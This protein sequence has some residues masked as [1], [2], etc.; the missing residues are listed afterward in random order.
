MITQSPAK[1]GA[2]SAPK[3]PREVTAELKA[4]REK[5][6]ADLPKYQLGALWNVLDDALTPEPRTRSVP[7]LWKWSEVRPR[8]MRAGELVTAKEA[9]RRVLYFLNPGLP[10]EK[11]SAVG[12]LYAGIQLI[13][14]GE[15]AR[16][17]HHTPAATRFIIEGE[18][19]YTTVSGERTLM[20][21]GDYVTTPNWTWHDHGNESD[22]PMLW[23]DGLDVPLVTELD[24]V[25]FE[26]FVERTGNEVQPVTKPMEDASHRWA[27]N[28]RPTYQRHAGKFSPI[29][30]YRWDDCRSALQ[31]LR[32]DTG[33]PFDGIVL[34]YINPNTGGPS[35]PTMS[36]YLQLI[37][38]SEHTKAHRHTASTVYHV[39]EGRGY[40][41]IGGKRFDW[42]EGDTFVVPSWS[43]HEHASDGGEAVLFS[44]SDRP[45]LEA[46]DLI[47]EQ[48]LD[49]VPG[50]F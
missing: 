43:W 36:A 25:F 1:E 14:P 9:E 2:V 46:F 50:G 4:E 44:F 19:A 10:P 24:A 22:K 37:R 6:Y 16:T 27:K 28:L 30:N 29:L 45:V 23:L 34:E 3:G 40:S 18:R 33:S 17:H 8:V 13:L 26:L 7:Y 41:V 21:K 32:D 20:K 48:P 49:E 11:I 47:R 5:F 12:T 15:I 39:A 38:S 42:A 31:A 35:L